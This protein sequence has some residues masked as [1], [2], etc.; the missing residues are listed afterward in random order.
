[1]LL[2]YSDVDY[3]KAQG[4]LKEIPCEDNIMN[5]VNC[6]GI[7]DVSYADNQLE[8]EI[9]SLDSLSSHTV[10]VDVWNLVIIFKACFC[11]YY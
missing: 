11:K 8:F 2:V 4:S 1:M 9:Y 10:N 6:H 7:H 3:I 5:H